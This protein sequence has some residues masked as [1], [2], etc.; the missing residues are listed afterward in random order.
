MIGDD[1]PLTLK[2]AF[3]LL[4]RLCGAGSLDDQIEITERLKDLP[5]IARRGRRGLY[6]LVNREDWRFRSPRISSGFMTRA[7]GDLDEGV[8]VV[9]MPG[10]ESALL[11]YKPSVLQFYKGYSWEVDEDTHREV[12]DKIHREVDEDNSFFECTF[13]RGDVERLAKSWLEDADETE[14]TQRQ[15]EPVRAMLKKLYQPHG[16]RPKGTSVKQVTDRLNKL[17]EFRNNPVSEDTVYRAF[18][19]IE[20]ALEATRKK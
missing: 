20:A 17:P 14:T 9:P 1:A 16:L 15:R 18:K 12:D 3:E 7:G 8:D 6:R 13:R 5:M 10:E 2:E 11:F 4:M 19:D